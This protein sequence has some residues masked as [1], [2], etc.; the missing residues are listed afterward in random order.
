MDALA[1]VIARMRER[2]AATASR[3]TQD[4]LIGSRGTSRSSLDDPAGERVSRCS[5]RGRAAAA[6][7]M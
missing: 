5:P 3:V 1:A 7:S 4:V 2:I 6:R